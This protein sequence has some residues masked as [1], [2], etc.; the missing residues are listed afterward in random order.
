MDYVIFCCYDFSPAL[1][2]MPARH[3]TTLH[4][5]VLMLLMKTLL[6]SGCVNQRGAGQRFYYLLVDLVDVVF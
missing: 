5:G 4:G 2:C 6:T 1:M 3:K